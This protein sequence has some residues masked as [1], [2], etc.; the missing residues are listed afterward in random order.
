MTRWSLFVLAG[1][2]IS[3]CTFTPPKGRFWDAP[4]YARRAQADFKLTRYQCGQ[5]WPAFQDPLGLTPIMDYLHSKQN[6]RSYLVCME[7][8]G[9]EFREEAKP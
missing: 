6:W 1:L 5:D 3:G 7:A 8:H 4:G 2:V 9:Y